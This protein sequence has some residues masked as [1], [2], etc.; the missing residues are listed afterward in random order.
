[1]I[2]NDFI[3][4]LTVRPWLEFALGMAGHPPAGFTLEEAWS[5]FQYFAISPPS[6]RSRNSLFFVGAWQVDQTGNRVYILSLGRQVTDAATGSTPR[7]RTVQLQFIHGSPAQPVQEFRLVS[8]HYSSPVTFLKA[9]A[10]HPMFRFG[11]ANPTRDSRMLDEERDG[12]S[13]VV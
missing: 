9:V 11:V 8:S 5:P 7:T 4:T 12:T 6:K 1:M 13:P 10:D 3:T 2:Y